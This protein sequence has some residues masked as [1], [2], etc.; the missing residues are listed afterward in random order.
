MIDILGEDCDLL[1]GFNAD[2]DDMNEDYNDLNR[3][4][5]RELDE[6]IANNNDDV[7]TFDEAIRQYKVVIPLTA[8][9][10]FC[11]T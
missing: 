1:I 6:L 10:S 3:A 7:T 5:K 9:L 4:C 11:E 8:S 2:L